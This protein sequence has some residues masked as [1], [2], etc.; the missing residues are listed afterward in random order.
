MAH[1]VKAGLELG[2]IRSLDE[3]PDFKTESEEAD[4]WDTHAMSDELWDSLPP[5]DD[6]PPLGTKFGARI[7]ID[8]EVAERLRALAKKRQVS[9]VKLAR[10]FVMERLYEEEKREGIIGDSK[11]S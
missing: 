3:I 11:A 1:M 5:A 7:S 2:V 4:F 6:L 9:Y 10:Q 8:G